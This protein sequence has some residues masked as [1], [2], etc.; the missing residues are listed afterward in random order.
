MISTEIIK[1]AQEKN[2]CIEISKIKFCIFFLLLWKFVSVSVFCFI[3]S[4]FFLTF[5]DFLMYFWSSDFSE[6]IEICYNHLVES[7]IF[8]LFLLNL[9]NDFFLCWISWLLYLK[10]NLNFFIR[11]CIQSVNWNSS[12]SCLSPTVN[13]N[14]STCCRNLLCMKTYNSCGTRPKRGNGL[15]LVDTIYLIP[16]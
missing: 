13:L 15:R 11:C 2:D 5:N 16:S 12:V 14:S 4:I 8:F 10:I 3:F 6:S 9:K 7:K 1:L